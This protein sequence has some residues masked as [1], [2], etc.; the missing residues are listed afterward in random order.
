MYINF[1]VEN[2]NIFRD[3]HPYELESQNYINSEKEKE[4]GS[5]NNTNEILDNF[6]GNKMEIEDDDFN[7]LFIS[8]NPSTSESEIKP[9]ISNTNL[10]APKILFT[11]KKEEIEIPKIKTKMIPKILSINEINNIIRLYD[12]GAEVKKNLLLPKEINCIEMAI[13]KEELEAEGFRKRKQLKIINYLNEKYKPG[14]KKINDNSYRCHNKNKSDNIICYLINILN[15]SLLGFINGIINIL[16]SREEI[17]K[18][19]SE[20]N[21]PNNINKHHNSIEVIKKNNYKLRKCFMKIDKFLELLDFTLKDYYSLEISPKF[22]D[23][24]SRKYNELILNKLLKKENNNYYQFFNLIL[25]EIKISDFF[26]IFLHQKDFEELKIYDLLN[27]SQKEMI[28]NYLKRIEKYFENEDKKDKTY[29]HCFALVI[30]NLKRLLFI[31]EIRKTK[32][33]KKLTNLDKN[34]KINNENNN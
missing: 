24:Y 1:Y 18:I 9:T 19:L 12:V 33:K 23:R 11:I 29:F 31:K 34:E 27:A 8:K 17:N 6:T 13:I 30:Y 5:I 10:Q 3:I 4:N 14:R 15:K 21:L 26:D 20:L 2:K 22:K 28:E 32:I 16:L 25:N 7:H